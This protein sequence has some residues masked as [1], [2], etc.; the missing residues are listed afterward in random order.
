ME[1]RRQVTFT[2]LWTG[3]G[4]DGYCSGFCTKSYLSPLSRFSDLLFRFIHTICFITSL[5]PSVI[6][7]RMWQGGR[8]REVNFFYIGRWVVGTYYF[9]LNTEA[10]FSRLLQ[11]VLISEISEFTCNF[12]SRFISGKCFL[13]S[14]VI[15]YSAV[16][17][18]SLLLKFTINNY[19]LITNY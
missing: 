2:T 13:R 15:S 10:C 17:I 6:K 1:E 5:P 14:K 8:E 18:Y 11:D 7:E 16:P 4:R 3:M 9:V 12:W 19:L